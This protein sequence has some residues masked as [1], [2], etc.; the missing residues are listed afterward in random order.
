[1]TADPE[2][3]SV[4]FHQLA[5]AVEKKQV[6][7]KVEEEKRFSLSTFFVFRLVP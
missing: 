3:S 5:A 2:L 6:I 7:E 4:F 1:M